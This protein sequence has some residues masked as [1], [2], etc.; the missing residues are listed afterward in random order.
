MTSS[1]VIGQGFDGAGLVV[2]SLSGLA[3]VRTSR[4]QP[5]H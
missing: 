4:R 5:L 2:G 1:L 3:L